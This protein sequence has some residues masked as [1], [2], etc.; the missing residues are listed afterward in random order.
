MYDNT[1]ET[2]QFETRFLR[3]LANFNNI[4]YQTLL[5][6]LKVQNERQTQINNSRNYIEITAGYMFWMTGKQK[7]DINVSPFYVETYLRVA[8]WLWLHPVSKKEDN[9]KL[10]VLAGGAAETV[11]ALAGVEAKRVN[12]AVRGDRTASVQHHHLPTWPAQ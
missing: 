10:K 2:F 9:N 8:C 3:P 7:E 12:V 11:A 4:K 1:S 5:K 6:S